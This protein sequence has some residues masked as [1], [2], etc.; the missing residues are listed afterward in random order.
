MD[1]LFIALKIHSLLKME[2]Y[3]WR[4]NVTTKLGSGNVFSVIRTYKT[5]KIV[6][7]KAKISYE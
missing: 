6:S 4:D 7:L 3:W 5:D 1:I 2:I